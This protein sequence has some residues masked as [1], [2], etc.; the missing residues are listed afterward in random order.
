MALKHSLRRIRRWG[1][2]TPD[3]HPGRI[4]VPRAVR[5]RNAPAT[6][7]D[8]RRRFTTSASSEPCN[9]SIQWL[10]SRFDLRKAAGG[11]TARGLSKRTDAI[12][13]RIFMVCKILITCIRAS[14]Q[15]ASP[16]TVI[17]PEA[18]DV[19]PDGEEFLPRVGSETSKTSSSKLWQ[20]KIARRKSEVLRQRLP[21]PLRP[22]IFARTIHACSCQCTIANGLLEV[23]FVADHASVGRA[24][25][26]TAG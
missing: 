22:G 10:R 24:D 25:L 21:E 19:A 7:G 4:D 2:V 12:R 15:M 17:Q 13:C 6:F 11:C 14:S 20:R 23:G 8:F 18:H 5:P 9:R 1:I 16:I 26:P 3:H